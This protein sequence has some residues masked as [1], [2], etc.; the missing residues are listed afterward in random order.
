MFCVFSSPP[1]ECVGANNIS[2]LRKTQLDF[3][4]FSPFQK[5]YTSCDERFSLSEIY[6]KINFNLLIEEFLRPLHC[7]LT[8]LN[9][10]LS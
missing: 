8:K 3:I 6:D 4:K 9:Y 7:K 2:Q 5:F 10:T 1:F